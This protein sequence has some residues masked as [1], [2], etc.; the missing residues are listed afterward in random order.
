M[1]IFTGG[2]AILL[3]AYEH[4]MLFLKYFLHTSINRIPESVQRDQERNR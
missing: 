1:Y 3:F 2:V 4:L